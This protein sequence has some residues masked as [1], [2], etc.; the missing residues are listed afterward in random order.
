MSITE[1]LNIGNILAMAVLDHT[2]KRFPTVENITTGVDEIKLVD[3]RKSQRKDKNKDSKR[4]RNEKCKGNNSHDLR[5]D[6]RVKPWSVGFLTDYRF[7]WII[8][9]SF[10]LQGKRGKRFCQLS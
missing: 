7:F 5:F 10:K 2:V 4:Q 9:I 1:I 8:I 3:D 6:R